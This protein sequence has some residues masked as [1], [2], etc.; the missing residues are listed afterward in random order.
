MD[1]IINPERGFSLGFSWDIL[2]A[3]VI[4]AIPTFLICWWRMR[5]RAKPEKLNKLCLA[6][7][8]II[9]TLLIYIILVA[10]IS[11]VLVQMV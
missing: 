8:T 5:K 7:T 6:A 4:I 1:V 3:L 2:V 11:F 9:A 10:V